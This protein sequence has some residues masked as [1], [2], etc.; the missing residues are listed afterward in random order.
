MNFGLKLQ[1]A[2]PD[3]FAIIPAPILRTP[4]AIPTHYIKK[5]DLL[6]SE[7]TSKET[8]SNVGREFFDAER[9][10]DALDF[11]EKAKDLNGLN[12][13][14]QYAV[15]SGDTFLLSRLDRFDRTLISRPDWDAAA[16]NAQAAG[17]ESM[18]NFAA[19]KFAAET[20]AAAKPALPGST[21]LAEA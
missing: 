1:I 5:R 19:R 17:R 4:V 9:Y 14:K 21:P 10:S 6:H 12:E 20:A 7:K 11:Y 8:L 16:Q 3:S 2:S 13:I 18:A 15:K